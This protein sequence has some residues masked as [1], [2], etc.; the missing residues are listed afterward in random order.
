MEKLTIQG[1][2]YGYCQ[3]DKFLEDF[4]SE[5]QN[6]CQ[7]LEL[8]YLGL[9]LKGRELK[10]NKILQELRLNYNRFNDR[11]PKISSLG[12]VKTLCYLHN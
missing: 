8:N 9:N 7:S 6:K 3:I 12:Q 4:F 1:N 11:G 5:F 2:R 10:D